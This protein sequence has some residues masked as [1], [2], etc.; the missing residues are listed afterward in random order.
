MNYKIEKVV[1]VGAGTMG[2]GI[3]ALIAGV[4]IPVTLLDLAAKDGD[5]NSV[6]KSLWDRQLKS[7]PPALTSGSRA[8]AQK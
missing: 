5:R 2:G 4:G 7:N 8:S 3:A 1:V 6:V